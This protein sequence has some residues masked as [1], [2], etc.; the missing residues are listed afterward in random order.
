MANGTIQKAIEIML[1][2]SPSGIGKMGPRIK[3]LIENAKKDK[4]KPKGRTPSMIL[5]SASKAGMQ[6]KQGKFPSVKRKP[7]QPAPRPKFPT[8]KPGTIGS[9]PKAIKKTNGRE[10]DMVENFR[11]N[12]FK[13]IPKRGR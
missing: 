11:K 6:S 12:R 9:K 10:G 2:A 3:K 1:S 7:F 8:R 13:K 5:G 4:G